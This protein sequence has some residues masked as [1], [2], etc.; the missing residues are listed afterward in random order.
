MISKQSIFEL[1]NGSNNVPSDQSL[2]SNILYFFLEVSFIVIMAAIKNFFFLEF[3]KF[4]SSNKGC[5]PG[6]RSI[7]VF[8]KLFC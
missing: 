1:L 5:S 8:S 7:A 2:L 6:S 3:L 4:E